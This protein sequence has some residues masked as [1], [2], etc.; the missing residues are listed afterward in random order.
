LAL[1]RGE[2]PARHAQL[3]HKYSIRQYFERPVAYPQTSIR[4]RTA[5]PT[6]KG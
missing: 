5:T 3:V 4:G 2:W 1:A 6:A